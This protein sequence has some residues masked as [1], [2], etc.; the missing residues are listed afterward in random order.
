MQ[1]IK[2]FDRECSKLLSKY[3]EA[4]AGVCLFEL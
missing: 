4:V 2:F 3:R 1:I